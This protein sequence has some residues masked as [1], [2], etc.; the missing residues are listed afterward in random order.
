M[1]KER[2]EKKE[3]KK[4]N[5][6]FD[7]NLAFSSS[8]ALF[9]SASLRS[10]KKNIN[11]KKMRKMKNQILIITKG[12]SFPFNSQYFS[13]YFPPHFFLFLS[14]SPPPPYIYINLANLPSAL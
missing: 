4:K 7:W 3:R 10:L 12:C 8:F 14:L 5:F 2:G 11:K 13:T 6:F 9:S 1:R